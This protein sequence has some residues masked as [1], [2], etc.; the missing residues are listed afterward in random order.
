[1]AVGALT[2][3]LLALAF[4]LRGQYAQVAAEHL[5][6]QLSTVP[7]DSVRVLMGQL[8]ALG[9]PGIPVLVEALG[10]ERESVALAGKG[11]LLD[12]FDR[13]RT[14]PPRTRSARLAALAAALADNVEGFRATARGDAAELASRILS[15]PLDPAA[16]DCGRVISSC[17]NVLRATGV[18]GSLT[19]ETAAPV[20]PLPENERADETRRRPLGSESPL[21]DDISP[22]ELSRFPGGGLP[23]RSVPPAELQPPRPEIPRVADVG[24]G[25]PRHDTGPAAPQSP[26]P[27][28]Q[29]GRLWVDPE[30]ARLTP[31]RPVSPVAP[32]QQL[33]PEPP[34]PLSPS[35]PQP[36]LQP[37]QVPE[38]QRAESVELMRRLR[39]GDGWMAAAAE[40]ELVRRG[41]RTVDVELARKLFDPDPEVRKQ[42]AS[43]LPR[44][45]SVDPVPWL[46]Q[47]GRDENSDV[48]LA[49]IGL[50]ATTG[51]PTL[52]VQIEQMAQGDPDPRIQR[53]ARRIAEHWNRRTY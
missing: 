22:A 49:A 18:V 5:R 42:L 47:L 17:E 6:K 28:R 40:A 13:W 41:F 37:A 43:V 1:M 16:V 12:Q 19:A 3:V 39:T 9:E 14:L 36:S 38:L 44:L 26:N 27:L 35:T 52:L 32:R 30:Y 24:Q 21:P 7:D 11:V 33:H 10:S 46:L 15:W 50:M 29:P 53:Q 2:A 48:R 45:R 34:R 25:Q 8:A 4:G 20:Q 31:E 23:I 51:D